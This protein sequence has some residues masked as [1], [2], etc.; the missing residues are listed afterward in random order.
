M[1]CYTRLRFM[2][3]IRIRRNEK[4]PS[5]FGS[6]SATLAKVKKKLNNILFWGGATLQQTGRGNGLVAATSWSTFPS[7]TGTLKP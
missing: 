4:D 2:K 1:F 7:A 5:G 6:G 3:R